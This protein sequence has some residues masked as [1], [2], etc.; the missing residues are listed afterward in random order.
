MKI[1]RATHLSNHLTGCNA[2]EAVKI[3]M[4]NIKKGFLHVYVDEYED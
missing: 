3:I 4:N 2:F 1:V